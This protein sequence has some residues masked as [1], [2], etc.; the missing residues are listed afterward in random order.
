MDDERCGYIE[1]ILKP[2]GKYECIFEK[3]NYTAAT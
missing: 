1:P 2:S 3:H